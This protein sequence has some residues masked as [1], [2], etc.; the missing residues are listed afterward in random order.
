MT[1]S[2]T[3][4]PESSARSWST[5]SRGSGRY[6][7]DSEIGQRGRDRLVAADAGDLLGDVGLD[8]A[9][10][11]GGVGTIATSAPAASSGVSGRGLSPSITGTASDAVAGSVSTST[12]ASSAACSSAETSMPSRRE[13]RAGRN[14]SRRRR[15]LVRVRVDDADRRRDRRPTR[16]SAARCGRHRCARA[17]APGPSRSAGWPRS[18]ARTG[19]RCGGCSTGSKMADSTTT[20]VVV[21]RRPR[22]CAPPMTPAMPSGPRGVG[23]EQH[24]RRRASRSTWSS[25]SSCSPAVAARTM[26]VPPRDGGGV[27]G[28]DGLAQLEH[29]VVAGVDD[30]ADG[31][32]ARRQQSPL[33]RERATAR[34]V[35]PSR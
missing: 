21:V 29:H 9:G 19:T 25:V 4:R 26:I 14:G 1:T 28:V 34:R 2:S 17:G 12:R 20:A 23:D 5:A 33:D 22:W 10:R 15:R 31:S 7:G 11:G 8:G 24:V 30:V 32:H 18:A 3:P 27:E 16:R 6:G 35:T 13:T